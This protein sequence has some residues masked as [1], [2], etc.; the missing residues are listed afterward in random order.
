MEKKADGQGEKTP[1]WHNPND[2]YW[3]HRMRSQAM[4]TPVDEL[5][6]S[7][8]K[9]R[10]DWRKAQ[11]GWQEAG[12]A[13]GKLKEGDQGYAEA[14]NRYD[15]WSKQ[16][17][18]ALRNMQLAHNR[19]AMRLGIDD[20]AFHRQEAEINADIAAHKQKLKTF[21]DYSPLGLVTQPLGM[22][23]HMTGHRSP[24]ETFMDYLSG[25]TQAQDSQG[26]YE[27][28]MTVAE[29]ADRMRSAEL[30]GKAAGAAA[31]IPGVAVS[32]VLSTPKALQLAT[33]GAT[34]RTAL[35]M[36]LSSGY[37]YKGIGAGMDAAGNAMQKSRN[38]N[39]ALLGSSMSNVGNL[40]GSMPEWTTWMGMTG[41]PAW[42]SK[43]KAGS[44]LLNF[45]N[46]KFIPTEGTAG[47]VLNG[48]WKMHAYSAPF[49]ALSIA[50]QARDNVQN[51][52]PWNYAIRPTQ[53]YPITD[54]VL[55]APTWFFD[56]GQADLSRGQTWRQEQIDKNSDYWNS[57]SSAAMDPKS[58]P[59]E[60]WSFVRQE[61]G[62]DP[63][64][65]PEQWAVYA[66]KNN[67]TGDDI[68]GMLQKRN[69]VDMLQKN[70]LR[71]LSE[72]FRDVDWKAMSGDEVE[73]RMEQLGASRDTMKSV[74]HDM[75]LAGS[76]EL[77]PEMLNDASLSDED[78][79]SLFSTLATV[80]DARQGGSTYGRGIR[81]FF[82]GDAGFLARLEKK[83]PEFRAAY[84]EYS[85]WRTRRALESAKSG[86]LSD[87]GKDLEKL[88]E[89][90]PEVRERV[91]Q[92]LKA[93]PK[94]AAAIAVNGRI[95]DGDVGKEMSGEVF[96]ELTGNGNYFVDFLDGVKTYGAQKK[97]DPKLF[98]EMTT[99]F[100]GM[101]E[102]QIGKFMDNMD[103]DHMDRFGAMLFTEDGQK[104]ADSLSPAT[105]KVLEDK[106]MGA[107]KTRLW[108]MCAENPLKGFPVAVGLWMRMQGWQGMA[109]IASNPLAFWAFAAIAIGGGA[110]MM[111]SLMG[112]GDEEEDDDYGRGRRGRGYDDEDIVRSVFGQG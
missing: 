49:G 96:S 13:L 36:A 106:F 39:V 108:K 3:A 23:S 54:K 37:L 8:N 94:G 107:A 62:L 45:V 40:A 11:K 75:F 55:H 110:L 12:E 111:G 72:K 73:A 64:T 38:E 81:H 79:D 10:E 97:A 16:H 88:S 2:P 89:A 35:E 15:A 4:S 71:V 9:S 85:A 47:K 14:K 77:V 43:T 63:K 21:V 22:A 99:R 56:S 65:T 112:G 98:N 84:G 109:G 82:Q 18:T 58:L 48:L 52:R 90:S 69:A 78:K 5:N 33:Q 44:A 57:I 59:A 30:A 34:K 19:Y 74:Y 68:Y 70:K 50:M 7:Y 53:I 26:A 41:V 61:L 17:D 1:A 60:Q 6:A 29:F 31:W 42:L 101:S 105:R 80:E 32:G 102:E 93:D 25:S 28:G 76:T 83:S 86:K 95:S 51:G 92:E 20:K 91:K 27:N 100:T 103:L 46:G 66:E 24:Y 67:L 87:Y 104:F